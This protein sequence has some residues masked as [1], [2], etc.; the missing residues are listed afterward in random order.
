MAP[1][2]R[3]VSQQL[4]NELLPVTVRFLAD[5]WDETSQTVHTLL[6]TVLGNVS[7]NT[8]CVIQMLPDL[9]P[10]SIRGLKRPVRILI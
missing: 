8:T 5:E 6:S 10:I 1:D 3:A 2:L 7:R 4:L 9:V